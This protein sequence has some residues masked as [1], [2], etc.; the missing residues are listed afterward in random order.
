MERTKYAN[1]KRDRFVRIA[2]KRVNSIL[3]NLN[4]LGNCANKRNYNY[5]GEDVRKIF[6]EIEKKVREIKIKFTSESDGV[7]S[8]R[9]NH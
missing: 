3:Q 5:D 7:A 8:F 2:E 9:L 4:S 1:E 6:A